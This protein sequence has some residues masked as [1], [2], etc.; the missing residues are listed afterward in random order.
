MKRAKLIIALGNAVTNGD[1]EEA[2]AKS[3][4]AAILVCINKDH[5]ESLGMPYLAVLDD[6]G[7]K[8]EKL[9]TA[10]AVLTNLVEGE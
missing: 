1:L 2:E 4:F 5:N 10:V 8:F 3:I 9:E 7:T 6:L